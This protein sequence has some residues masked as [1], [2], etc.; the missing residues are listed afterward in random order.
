MSEATALRVVGLLSAGLSIV[1][2][3]LIIMSFVLWRDL[4][5]TT[6]RLLVYLSVCDLVTALFNLIGLSTSQARF[7]NTLSHDACS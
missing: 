2:S 3:S 4:R 6:R 5:T 1:G 7:G